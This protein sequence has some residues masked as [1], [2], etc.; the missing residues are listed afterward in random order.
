MFGNT[1]QIY[2][3]THFMEEEYV[4]ALL[5]PKIREVLDAAPLCK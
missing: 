5:I 1:F 2:E 4:Y 3:G